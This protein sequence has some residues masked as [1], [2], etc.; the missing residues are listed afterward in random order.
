MKKPNKKFETDLNRLAN[1]FQDGHMMILTNPTG[2]VNKACDEI[3]ASRIS[4]ET[5]SKALHV[6]RRNESK[7]RELQEDLE[8]YRKGLQDIVDKCVDC[9]DTAQFAHGLLYKYVKLGKDKT[10]I[11]INRKHSYPRCPECGRAVVGAMMT[12]RSIMHS[13]GEVYYHPDAISVYCESGGC[14]WDRKIY[15]IPSPSKTK[16]DQV[17]YNFKE[18]GADDKR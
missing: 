7:V 14:N 15:Q 5:L 11:K 18:R 12:S 9:P 4:I 2:L 13:D 10:A 17:T 6:Y 16:D 1:L 8:Y 3:E